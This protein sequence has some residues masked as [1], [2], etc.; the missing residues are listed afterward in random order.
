MANIK[1]FVFFQKFMSFSKSLCLFPKVYVFFQKFMSLD[2]LEHLKIFL[3]ILTFYIVLS[4]GVKLTNVGRGFEL[5]SVGTQACVLPI[6]P[7]FLV[8][9]KYSVTI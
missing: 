4:F 7:T 5:G 3:V 1:F 8:E 6:E 2:T 9:T